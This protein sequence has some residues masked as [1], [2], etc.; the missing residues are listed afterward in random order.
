MIKIQYC[1]VLDDA[2][3]TAKRYDLSP[4]EFYCMASGIL[5]CALRDYSVSQKEYAE[6]IAY[7]DKIVEE[8]GE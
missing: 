6:I 3:S 2:L 5:L 1:R 7:K 8:I 4:N